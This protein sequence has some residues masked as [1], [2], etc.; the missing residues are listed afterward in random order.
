VQPWQTL[1]KLRAIN[2]Q[3]IKKEFSLLHHM[4]DINLFCMRDETDVETMNEEVR[5]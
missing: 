1:H 5:V 4:E 3:N 2:T